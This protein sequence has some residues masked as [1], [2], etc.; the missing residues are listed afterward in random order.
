MCYLSVLSSQTLKSGHRSTVRQG[1]AICNET[2]G[3]PDLRGRFIVRAGNKHAVKLTG[4]QLS[5]TPT[6]QV[7]GTA[8]TQAQ[9]PMHNHVGKTRTQN[10]RRMY[11][12]LKAPLNSRFQSGSFRWL[13]S[14]D[15]NGCT[16]CYHTHT[17]SSDGENQ[18]HT[19]EATSSPIDL[20]PP[21]YALFIL[22]NCR[23][24]VK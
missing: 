17:I 20:L 23:K 12:D 24:C 6:I 11:Y 19:H 22:R 10:T 3:A 18:A 14:V 16:D 21:Y 4:S 13:N 8:L 15:N 1:W 2:D 9:M 5:V 7:Q